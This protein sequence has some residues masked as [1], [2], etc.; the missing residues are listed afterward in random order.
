LQDSF[1]LKRKERSMATASS[2]SPE[3]DAL[4]VDHP[5]L[6]ALLSKLD[7][8]L[9]RRLGVIEYTHS[10]DC[11][12]RMQV[13]KSPCQQALSDGTVL[14]RG[15]R[16]VILHLW[17]EQI[18]HFPEG[19]PTFSWARRFNRSFDISLRELAAYLAA[20]HELDDVVAVYAD[21]ALGSA[22]QS[23]QLIRIVNRY[24][25][26]RANERDSVSL[27]ERMHRF[28]ENVLI[29]MMVFARNGAALRRDTLWRD[30]TLVLL[31]RRHLEQRY[32][33]DYRRVR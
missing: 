7:D 23:D 5:R 24:G 9:R 8:H 3:Q 29:V 26:E 28:G 17:N 13:S 33:S 20:H 6:G 19:G 16:V 12:F 31:S 27:V 25:F 2:T 32:G 1:R 18:R 10:P 11:I 15:D 22:Q 4:R 21:I 30:R 14:R